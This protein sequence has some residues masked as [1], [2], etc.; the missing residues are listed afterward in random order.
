MPDGFRGL[1][2]RAE[3]WV[4]HTMAPVLDFAGYFASEEYFHNLIATLRPGVTIDR[5]QSELNVIG[6]RIGAAVPA[7]SDRA[8]R[9]GATMIP[10]AEAQTN[11]ADVRARLYVALGAV[12]VLLVA[13]INLANLVATRVASRQREFSVRLAMGAGR[14][15]LVRS[16]GAEMT[17]VAFAG[18]VMALGLAAWT[19]DLVLLIVPAGLANP[20]NDYGQLATFT[21]LDLDGVVV[22]VVALLALAV[23]A[24]ASWLGARPA[25]RADL[26]AALKSGD[27]ASTRGPGRGERLLLSLQVAASISLVASAALVLRSVN[28]LDNVDP[29]FDPSRVVAFSVEED[30][31]AQRPGAGPVMV[32]RL[33][34]GLA[35]VRGVEAISVGQCAPFSARCARQPLVIE[36]RP[37]TETTPLVTGWHRVGPGHFKALRI[38]VIRGR[39]FTADD[40]RGRAAVVAINQAAARRYFSDQ[41][42]IGRRLR[43]PA[44]FPG[45]PDMAEIVAVV[46]DVIYWPLDE[47]PRADVYQPALQYALPFTTVM[48]RVTPEAWREAFPLIA[49]RQPIFESLRRA[50]AEVDPN[51]PI[52]NAAVLG[53]LARAG[54][55]DR[56]FVSALLTVCAVLA[57]LLAA[58]GIYGLTAGWFQSRRKELGV[59]VA[60]GASPAGLV[61]TVMAG[62]LW[63]TGLGVVGGIALAIGFGQLLRGVLFG[64][65]PNDPTA[66]AFSAAVM[67]GVAAVAAWLPA[68]RALR[69]DPAEQLRA[70]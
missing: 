27:R 47:A 51:L 67:L 18:F 55:A 42:P 59:R 23:M 68:R 35:N 21:S 10:L 50:M 32:A 22:I 6:S 48:V 13:A 20:G 8:T 24:A 25:L 15:H 12:L 66:L 70:D 65:G 41:D 58:V 53:D 19:R 69:I 63:Q 29:G 30:L 33:L 11:A 44:V 28:A 36:G 38:P 56:R 1:S 14:L 39:D 60:L 40:R 54:R 62:A 52:F 31:A 5:A 64:I 2:G 57:L 49:S 4:P 9:R 37:E 61:G 43:L 16:I 17:M 7:R 3:A 45:D 34:A 26:V 46:G